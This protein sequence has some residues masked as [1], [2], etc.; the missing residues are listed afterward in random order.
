MNAQFD[1]S[2]DEE[3]RFAISLPDRK[4][5]TLSRYVTAV[6]FSGE[7]DMFECMLQYNIRY[8][9]AP[10]SIDSLGSILILVGSDRAIMEFVTRELKIPAHLCV[11]Q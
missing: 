10:S 6:D 8:F 7:V 9:F 1:Y 3:P 11:R 5:G 4:T 2:L